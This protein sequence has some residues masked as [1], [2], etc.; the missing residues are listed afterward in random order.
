MLYIDEED[1]VTHSENYP[2]E[3]VSLS[4]EENQE[5]SKTRHERMPCFEVLST[6]EEK[7]DLGE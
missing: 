5:I 2:V 3:N 6:F 1:I 7:E 4:H